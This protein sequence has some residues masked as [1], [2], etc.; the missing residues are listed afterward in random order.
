MSRIDVTEK[1]I[2]GKVSRGLRWADIAQRVGVSKE[3]I[4]AAC[5][6]QM[7]LNRDQAA[8]IGQIFDLTEEET[9]W[10]SVVP[11]KGSLPT[12]IPTDPLIYRFYELVNV[13]GT[14]FKELIHEEFGDGI[15]SAIDFKMEL[16]REPDPKGDRVKIV[17]SGKYLPYKTY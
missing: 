4:T 14:T 9:K 12:A 8:T 1:I 16:S 17:M 3:W 5:L 15:M 2:A 11:Y 10:L 13:Y 6:G 7:T